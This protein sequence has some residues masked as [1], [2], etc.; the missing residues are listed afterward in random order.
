MEAQ[1]AAYIVSSVRTAVGKAG[2]GTLKDY[3]PEELGAQSV[4]GAMDRVD[5]LEPEMVED[6]IMGCAFP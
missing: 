4:V 1:N 3:R 6:V 2:R 5:G